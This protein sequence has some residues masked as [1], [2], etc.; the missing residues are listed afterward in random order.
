M[1]DELVDDLRRDLA[2]QPG[3]DSGT[4]SC[5]GCAWC[6]Q[7]PDWF[8]AEGL[9]FCLE[10]RDFVLTRDEPCDGWAEC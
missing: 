4:P 10:Y 1:F 2:E 7:P 9:G 3:M 6:A 8:G 5:G